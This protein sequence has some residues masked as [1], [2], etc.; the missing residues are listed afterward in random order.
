[1]LK[2]QFKS[3]TVVRLKD[4]LDELSESSNSGFLGA[5]PPSLWN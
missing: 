4:K 1:M 2:V 3:L 5:V